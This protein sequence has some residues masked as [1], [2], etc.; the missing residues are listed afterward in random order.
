MCFYISLFTTDQHGELQAECLK[1]PALI[2]GESKGMCM[3]MGGRVVSSWRGM[4]CMG[5][6]CFV[7]FGGE[8]VGAILPVTWLWVHTHENK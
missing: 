2:L 1:F 8:R 3:V 6:L 7:V 5:M 4:S